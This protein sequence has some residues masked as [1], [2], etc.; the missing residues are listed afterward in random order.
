MTPLIWL[1]ALVSVGDSPWPQW[2]GPTRDFNVPDARLAASWPREGPRRVWSRE[3]GDGYSAILAD[4]ERLYTMFRRGDQNVAT[5]LDPATGKAVWEQPMDATPVSG[6]FLD[7][8]KGPNATPL[9]VGERLFVVTFTGRLAALDRRTG[10][11]LWQQELWTRHGGTFRDVGYSPS[12]IAYGDTIILPVGGAGKAVFA[13]RQSDGAVVWSRQD[14]ENAM[15]SPLLIR[16]DGQDQLVAFMVDHVVGLSPGTGDLL[17]SHPHRTDYAVN[18]ATPVWADGNI[19]VISSAYGTGARAIRLEQKGGKTSARELWAN[20]RLRVHH[21]NMVRIGEYVYGS[22]GDF[23]PAPLTAVHV[24]TGRVAWQDRRFPKATLLSA[25]GKV[26]VLDEDGRLALTTL[27]PE[28]MTVHSEAQILTKLAWT[29]PT[30]V[31]SRLY[32]RDRAT[33]A[34]YDVGP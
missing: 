9:L 30:L 24:P 14:F 13:F 28:G 32:V 3:L 21:G 11:V 15:A 2:G 5:A 12:P 16:V 34:A 26:I 33:I 17:W 4:G 25:A 31:G 18:A 10:R 23:G 27:T 1:L 7:Y 20:N 22:S 29:V 8:G 6:M 19:L